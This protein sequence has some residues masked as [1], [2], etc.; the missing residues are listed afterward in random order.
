MIKNLKNTLKI[1]KYAKILGFPRVPC[2]PVT[3]V[4]KIYNGNE[5][6]KGFDSK[7]TTGPAQRSTAFSDCSLRQGARPP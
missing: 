3:P 5:E 4:F 1:K 6:P 2:G 7:G